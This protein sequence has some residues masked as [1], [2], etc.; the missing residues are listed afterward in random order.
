M[1]QAREGLPNR[2][3]RRFWLRRGS[4]LRDFRDCAL[5]F[6][7]NGQQIHH[8]N[9]SASALARRLA[10]GATVSELQDSAAIQ[11]LGH[12]PDGSFAVE[13]LSQMA[14]LGLLVSSEEEDE[15]VGFEQSIVIADL[16]IRIQYGSEELF[17]Q[18][19][20]A[21][22]HLQAEQGDG[23]AITYRLSS[24]GPFALITAD[25][26]ASEV[27]ESGL[28][29][30]LFKGM[31][32]ERVLAEAEYL[33]A[34]HASALVKDGRIALL[35]GQPGAGKSTM[36]LTLAARGYAYEGDDVALVGSLGL[37]RGVCL[38]PAIKQP[39]WDIA[40]SYLPELDR[41]PIHRRPD[42]QRV[43]FLPVP[44]PPI[45]RGLPVS[46]IVVLDRDSTMPAKA[47]E[48]TTAEAMTA[49]ISEARSKD[50]RC[51]MET[52]DALA[53]MLATATCVRLRYGEAVD[54]A[55]LIETLGR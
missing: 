15:A 28:A 48:L 1:M 55:A 47:E 30:V 42:G 40:R 35:L 29:P 44:S 5:L 23:P 20:P 3:V 52:F 54:A 12:P 27:V 21:Y 41:L 9:P 46:T 7:E 33:C 13:F 39:A 22:A 17:D 38:A 8:L 25:A 45:D 16:P 37:V 32:L 14:E 2:P 11:E 19:A 4:G 6:C 49:L 34:L 50:G 36:A 51:S 10:D 53:D 18:L 43:R 31:L 24:D 26:D